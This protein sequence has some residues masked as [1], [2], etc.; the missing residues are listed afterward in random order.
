M[1]LITFFTDNA[2]EIITFIF[3]IIGAII[4]FLVQRKELLKTVKD[5]VGRVS[6]LEEHKQNTEL[7]LVQIKTQLENI[8]SRGNETH[9]VILLIQDKL[10]KSN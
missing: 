10:M 8:G 5:L 6:D 4:A 7:A 9:A 1:D 3:V 2:T